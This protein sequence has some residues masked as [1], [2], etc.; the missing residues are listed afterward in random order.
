MRRISQWIFLARSSEVEVEVGRMIQRI[1]FE[2]TRGLVGDEE[3]ACR[4]WG[5]GTERERRRRVQIGILR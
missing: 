2:T 4:N 1:T 5:M 3:R